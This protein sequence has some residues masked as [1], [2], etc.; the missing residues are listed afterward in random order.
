MICIKEGPWKFAENLGKTAP[1]PKYGE[2]VTVTG[3]IESHNTIYYALSGYGGYTYDSQ[4]FVSP[5]DFDISELTE[6][7]ENT[8]ELQS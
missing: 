7:L 4:F 8:E 5:E 2:E 3:K 1:G 6:I